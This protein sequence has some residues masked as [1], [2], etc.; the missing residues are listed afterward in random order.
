MKRI[1]KIIC[2]ARHGN[3]KL[4]NWE[5]PTGQVKIL[6]LLLSIIISTIN[7]PLVLGENNL[8]KNSGFETEM[9]NLPLSWQITG[10]YKNKDSYRVDK[11]I[12]KT[13]KNSLRLYNKTPAATDKRSWLKISQVINIAGGDYYEFSFWIKGSEIVS[14]DNNASYRV[15]LVFSG[16]KVARHKHYTYKLPAGKDGFDWMEVKDS[17]LVPQGINKLAVVIMM[18]SRTTSGKVWF[19]DFS[20]VNLSRKEKKIIQVYPFKTRFDGEIARLKK[21]MTREVFSIRG[22]PEIDGILNDPCWEKA[23]KIEL[24]FI[25]GKSGKYVK[26]KTVVSLCNDENNL[27]LAFDCYTADPSKIKTNFNKHDAPLWYD[28]CV[29]IFISALHKKVTAHLIANNNG[30]KWEALQDGFNDDTSW[31]P[32][33]LV[34]TSTAPKAWKAE[35]SIPLSELTSVLGS[36]DSGWSVNLCRENKI[37]GENSSICY[38]PESVSFYRPA[39]FAKLKFPDKESALPKEDGFI[40]KYDRL[41]TLEA[42][43]IKSI[44]SKDKK[45]YKFKNIYDFGSNT[46]PICDGF[47]Q[48]TPK[49]KYSSSLGYGWITEKNMSAVDREADPK[50]GSP[51]KLTCDFIESKFNASFRINVPDGEYIVYVICGDT[52]LPAPTFEIYSDH[53]KIGDIAVGG[54]YNFQP[55]S[56]PVTVSNNRLLLSFTG[57]YGWLINALVVYPKKDFL[58]AQK[59]LNNLEREI[60]LG[61]VNYIM[62]FVKYEHNETN[63]TAEIKNLYHTDYVVFSRIYLDDVFPNTVPLKKEVTN[64]LYTFASPGE[65]EPVTFSLLPLKDLKNVK[66]D[67]SE[68]TGRDG[69]KIINKKNIKLREVKYGYWNVL[70]SKPQTYMLYPRILANYIPAGIDKHKTTRFWISIKIPKDSAA[71]DYSGKI[72]ICPENSFKTTL[73]LRLK[74]LPIN[75]IELKTPFFNMCYHLPLNCPRRGVDGWKLIENDLTDMKE[76]NMNSVCLF[77]IRQNAWPEF[78]QIKKSLNVETILKFLRLCKKTGLTGPVIFNVCP[79][80]PWDPQQSPEIMTLNPEKW[81]F[82][83]NALNELNKKIHTESLPEIWCYLDEPYKP[84][85]K[86]NYTAVIRFLKQNCPQIKTFVTTAK[87]FVAGI[88]VLCPGPTDLSRELGLN[89]NYIYDMKKRGNPVWTYNAACYSFSSVCDKFGIGFLTWRWGVEGQMTFTYQLYYYHKNPYNPLD[90]SVPQYGHTFPGAD[91]SVPTITWEVIREGI[92]DLRYIK[93]LEKHI[94]SAQKAGHEKSKAVIGA[95]EVLKQLKADVPLDIS[96][97]LIKNSV[98]VPVYDVILSAE[99]QKFYRKKIADAIIELKKEMRK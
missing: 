44:L 56:F 19:D 42:I 26:E 28:D 38:S 21:D 4:F 30:T 35:I 32:A 77:I 29:E 43:R 11:R 60:Y 39:A 89:S 88:D 18:D 55:F 73:K 10:R 36:F 67:I 86:A 27:Y 23:Q 3:C 1:V 31:N 96:K 46:S 34:S 12:R 94:E 74:V 80:F 84:E 72:T 58:Q 48:V 64:E 76:H 99:K 6:F 41:K 62:R 13:G 92:D 59:E 83:V 57:K 81:H 93:T 95:K 52:K 9:K 14:T 33:W 2:D 71:G 91:E 22:T 97:F 51:N 79:Y 17:F 8:I 78:G 24:S 65:Y 47:L 49:T 70:H 61:P 75:L 50:T 25:P 45:I 20:L 16:D 40:K 87:R 7:C 66:I 98:G 54:R 69:E 53:D 63:H 5:K 85:R 68:L 37:N 82:V 90:N 15:A